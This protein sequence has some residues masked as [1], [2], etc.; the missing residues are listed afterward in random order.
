MRRKWLHIIFL[1]LAVLP[2]SQSLS[3]QDNVIRQLRASLLQ[4]TD[5]AAYTDVLNQLGMRYHLSNADSCFWYGV[6]ARSI[7][8]RHGDKK[9][10]AGSLNNLSIFYALKANMKQ[11]IEYAFKALL[12]YRE[13]EDPSNVCQV[14]M[15]LSVYHFYDGMK[16]E[17]NQYLFQAMD[18]GKTLTRDSIY[19]LVLI[20]YAIRFEADTTR[21]DS[22]KWAIE[23]SKS[24]IRKYPG[25]R[26]SYYI[27]AIEADEWMRDGEGAKAV[28]KINE[29]SDNA[30]REGLVVVAIDLLDHIDMYRRNGYPADAIP[31]KEKI[32]AV[33]SRA[34]YLNMMLP[35]VAS[36]Y[37]HY[38]AGNNEA[39][40]SFYGRALWELV[41]K[42][43]EL[44]S[45]TH[46][47]YLDYFLKEQELNEWQLSNKVQ[48]QKIVHATMKR[49]SRQQLIIFLVGFLVLMAG[50]TVFRYRSYKNLRRQ[51]ALLREM[52][53]AISEK[54]KQLNVHD[55][56]KNKLIAIL[57]R[58]FREP[59]NDIIRV[60]ALFGSK[61]MDQAA[62][63]KIIEEAVI[64]SRKTLVVFENILRW[65]RSQLSGFVYSPAPCNLLQLF[66]QVVSQTGNDHV[67]LDIQEELLLAGDQEML[68]FINRSLLHCA[69]SLALEGS[70]IQVTAVKEEQVRVSIVFEAAATQQ[71]AAH[72]F[73][74]R[75]GDDMSV[76]LVICK[77]FMDKMGGH[78]SAEAAGSQLRLGYKLP[79]FN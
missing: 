26:D 3:A 7:A 66:E 21:Q 28:Q 16:P 48:E 15:N 57:A 50:F 24:I 12:L 77:D 74:Y 49:A 30:L 6:K 68:L 31:A 1:L 47:N 64:S 44:K 18:L 56:F 53:D 32:F 27:Q 5:S 37:R 60:S 41:K 42:R 38:A 29:L 69:V 19:S 75:K 46:M 45:S 55:D 58:D 40:K 33:G 51:E 73:E 4:Q 34:G 76:T 23:H 67:I 43:L 79:S 22:V 13:V 39:R 71:M 10:L 62:M 2:G 63:Q 8:S 59:L 61:D 65:I 52:N 11:A 35:T 17:A 54:N 20:N 78:I 72:L 25:S 14:L 9:G 36:L 70:L